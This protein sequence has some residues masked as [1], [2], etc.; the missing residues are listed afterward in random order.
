MRAGLEGEREREMGKEKG[1]RKNGKGKKM[2]TR[3]LPDYTRYCSSLF[4]YT[5]PGPG[6]A[7]CARVTLS[8]PEGAP[9]VRPLHLPWDVYTCWLSGS[10]RTAGGRCTWGRSV[11]TVARE[12]TGGVRRCGGRKL[13]QVGPDRGPHFQGLSATQRSRRAEA[14]GGSG[15][16]GGGQS[17]PGALRLRGHIRVRGAEGGGGHRFGTSLLLDIVLCTYVCICIYVRMCVYVRIGI[18]ICK[19]ACMRI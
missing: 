5:R 2:P 4:P 9:W 17:C 7:P 15:R 12:L 13:P 6:A 19:H 11:P 1:K 14:R 3:R 10:P 16:R 18:Y 8:I